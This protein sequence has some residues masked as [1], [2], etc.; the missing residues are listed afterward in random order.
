[1]HIETLKTG[2]EFEYHGFRIVVIS[3]RSGRVKIG[4]VGP[5]GEVTEVKI[6]KEEKPV[7]VKA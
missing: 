6:E 2:D 7:A 3:V 4:V 1:M 5:D